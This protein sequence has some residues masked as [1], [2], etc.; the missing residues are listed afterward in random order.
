MYFYI[1]E[2]NMFSET[3]KRVAAHT[4]PDIN[5]RI[6]QQTR[7][8][9]EF[10]REQSID[11]ISQ[12]LQQLDEEWDTER[13]LQT[14]FSLFSSLGVLLTARVHRRWAWLALGVPTFMVQ[15]ALQGWCPPLAVLRRMGVRTAREIDEERFALKAIRGDFDDLPKVVEEADALLAAV[16]K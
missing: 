10:Y 6:E 12:R 7:A 9:I 5:L 15:H 4:Q 16:Q 8:S 13:V 2:N 1:R 3:A 11:V 14:N